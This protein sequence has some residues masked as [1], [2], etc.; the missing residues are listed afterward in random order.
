MLHFA[1][2]SFSADERPN[3][4]QLLFISS[5]LKIFPHIPH[6]NIAGSYSDFKNM[7]TDFE[8]LIQD[9]N[10]IFIHIT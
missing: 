8:N 4:T 5:C 3:L 10:N 7:R 1:V 6:K 9:F 2:S